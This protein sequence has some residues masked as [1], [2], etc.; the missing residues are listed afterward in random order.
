MRGDRALNEA[1][2]FGAGDVSPRRRPER[3]QL[4]QGVASDIV[5]PMPDRQQ[6]GYDVRPTKFLIVGAASFSN[7]QTWVKKSRFT[8]R[9]A[10]SSS[11]WLDARVNAGGVPTANP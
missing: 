1:T 11:T 9:M 10:R 7:S 5:P 3:A 2:R 4:S 8:R 6:L